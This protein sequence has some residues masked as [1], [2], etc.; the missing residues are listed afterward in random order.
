MSVEIRLVRVAGAVRVCC[1]SFAPVLVANSVLWSTNCILAERGLVSSTL[2]VSFADSGTLVRPVVHFVV[3]GC[4][5][6]LAMLESMLPVVS[7]VEVVRV[8]ARLTCWLSRERGVFCRAQSAV[9]DAALAASLDVDMSDALCYRSSCVGR[10]WLRWRRVA[11]PIWMPV[12]SNSA[13]GCGRV[14]ARSVLF[15][16]SL[17]ASFSALCIGND[18]DDHVV[19]VAQVCDVA[20]V[21][22]GVAVSECSNA[23]SLPLLIVAVLSPTRLLWSTSTL[24]H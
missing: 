11:R 1:F 16:W 5:R 2:R 17:V 3:I 24:V 15:P 9:L 21:F 14:W 7:Y 10:L 23:V 12:R 19:D 20:R 18:V 22:I 8:F 6:Q 4:D 13:C